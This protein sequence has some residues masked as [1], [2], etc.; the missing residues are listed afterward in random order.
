MRGVI[1]LILRFRAD[2]MSA[3]VCAPPAYLRKIEYFSLPLTEL[4]KHEIVEGIEGSIGNHWGFGIIIPALMGNLFVEH[5]GAL[6][7][8][9]ARIMRG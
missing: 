9:R 1:S 3:F 8:D 2:A 6:C 7:F 4:R 5:E